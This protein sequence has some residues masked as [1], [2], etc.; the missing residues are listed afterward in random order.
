M[1]K[2]KTEKIQIGI[3]EE[4]AQKIKIMTNYGMPDSYSGMKV[5]WSF[6]YIVFGRGENVHSS[7]KA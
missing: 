1:I 6:A 4:N 5:R 7:R 3:K 2:Y